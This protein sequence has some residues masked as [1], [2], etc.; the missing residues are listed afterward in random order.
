[1]TEAR[2]VRTLKRAVEAQG[3]AL[4][5]GAQVHLR[6][7]P[8]AVGQGI[9]FRRSDLED[10]P[11]IPA[12]PKSLAA[13]PRCTTLR[14]GGAEV[15]MVEHLL[16]AC[17]GMRVDDLDVV[18][19]GPE[20]PGFDGSALPYVELLERGGIVEQKGLRQTLVVSEPMVFRDDAGRELVVL[21]RDE[22]G[23]ALRYVP[24]HP[25]GVDPRPVSFVLGRDDFRTEIAP[26]R[27]FVRAEEIEALREA[28][29]GR[30]ADADNTVVLGGDEEPVF[31]ID[32][33]PTRHK[34]LDLIGDL[35]LLGADLQAEVVDL[36][37]GHALNQEAVRALRQ[38]LEEQM[39]AEAPGDGTYDIQAVLRL[40][41]H[42]YPFLMV[43]RVLSVDGWRR[44]VGVK[45]VTIN[46]PYFQG[47]FPGR[48][49]MPG[50]MQLEALAQLSGF[51]LQRKLEHAG[52]L[53]V[54]ASV[55]KVRFRGTVEPGDQLLLEVETLRLSQNR[56]QIRAQARV[57]SRVVSE[58]VLSFAMVPQE[59]Q[60]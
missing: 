24:D 12:L 32:R 42:R 59:Q 51:L 4:H 21:P 60:S 7:E 36:G 38:L 29:L 15:A 18:V 27:T 44:A 10:G 5:S 47:H 39:L 13:G 19:D 26:A 35:G 52:K 2:K 40:L 30:G 11:E 3:T 50:V 57:G 23:L 48:P 53:V 8:A 1:M 25:E 6:L 54:L 14:V 41:P 56:G 17:V 45:N 43:D 16:A 31:R 55:D 46:E 34:L 49:L 33:E 37:G 9:V 58:A 28:G 20:L 22:S